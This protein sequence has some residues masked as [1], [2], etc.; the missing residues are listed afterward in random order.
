[1]IILWILCG[2]FIVISAI[3]AVKLFLK[4]KDLDELSLEFKNNLEQE[5]NTLLM[6][7]TRNRHVCKIAVEINNGLKQLHQ[8]RRKYM[9]GDWELK[10]A[11]TNISH[12][13]RTPLT[14]ICGYLE[15]LEQEDNPE[16]M[17]S[18]I[19]QI[20]NRTE[21]MKEL[22]EELFRYSVIVS[23]WENTC[24]HVNLNKALE[25]CLLAYYGAFTQRQIEPVIDI[26]NKYIERNIDISAFN[27]IISNIL[28]N[29]LKYSDGDLYVKLSNNGTITFSNSA[30]NLTPVIVDRLFDRF[31]TVETGYS[32]TGLGLS[33]AKN[34]VERMGGNIQAYYEKSKLIILLN[35][36]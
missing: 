28:V 10:N 29:V 14:A 24:E 33:I 7:S 4:N 36:K 11:V 1:M 35:F 21:C 6:L 16:I 3:L 19:A 22:T 34:L 32:S 13:L 18:Y 23:S 20:Q 8:Q 17:K 9:N 15:L 12:D 27:R 26:C 30:L 25:E 2:F 31:Y 5:T